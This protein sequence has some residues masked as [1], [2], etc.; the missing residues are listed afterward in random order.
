[1]ASAQASLCETNSLEKHLIC[2]ICMDPF[3]DPVTTACG[4]SFCKTCLDC[5]FTYNDMKCPL[6]KELLRKT[7]DVN[8]ILRNIVEHMNK[9]REKDA[10]EYTGAPAEVA[11]DICTERKLKAKKSCLVCLA[12]YCSTHL[13]NHS[14]TER[15]KGH[16]LVEP[17]ENLDERACLKHGRPLELY[18]RKTE[19]CICALCIEE[20]QEEIV[21]TEDEWGKKKAKL[22][23][24]KTELKEK[25]TKRKTRM[26]EIDTSL[27]SCKDQLDTEWWDIDTVFTAVTAIVEEARATALKPLE[28]RREDV[29]KE[30]KSIK[31]EL[32]A[33]INS[34]EKTISELDNIS[35]LQDHILFLQEYPSLQKLDNL[36]DSTGVELHTSLS[37][38]TLRK[39]TTTM[40]EQ[41]QQRLEQLTSTELQRL[42]KFRVDVKLDPTTAHRRLVLSDDGKEVRDKGED[43][44]VDD[45][46]E[47]FDLFASILGLDALSSGKSFWEVE[48]GN[49]TGWDLG[50]ARSDANRKGK[51]P[52]NP[53]GG[54]WVIVH[55]EEEKYAAMT[56]PPVGLY[57]KEK[58]EKVGVFV[59]TK[60][61]LVSFYD[62]TAKSHIYSFTEGSFSDDLLPY[63]S[64]HEKKD[65]KNADP[66]IISAYKHCKQD[67]DI[68]AQ[69]KIFMSMSPRWDE[70]RSRRET[71][72]RQT[73]LSEPEE[74][75]GQRA[76]DKLNTSD[77]SL[78][79]C[80]CG[81]SKVTT[82]HGLRTHQGKMGCTPRGMSIPESEQFRFSSYR[83]ELTYQRPSIKVE[84]PY[85]FTP[86]LKSGSQQNT[87]VNQKDSGPLNWTTPV[88]TE[89]VL[90]SPH[91]T[92]T[93]PATDDALVE[94]VKSMMGKQILDRTN[95]ALHFAGGAQSSLRPV[96]QI[97]S[98]Q[99]NPAAAEVTGKETDQSAFQTP[100]HDSATHQ[101]TGNARRAL[102]FSTSAQQVGQQVWDIP[103]TTAQETVRPKEREQEKEKEKEDQKLQKARQ[104]RMRA[105]LQQNIQ[106][107]EQKMAEVRSSVKACKGGL[108]AEWLQINN[109]FSEVMRVV[110]DTRQKALQ[111]L[112]ERRKRAKREAQ[113]LVQ[114]LQ[115]EIDKLKMT[116]D[117][118]DK[119]P[120]LVSPQTGLGKTCDWRNVTVDT[121]FS[122]GTLRSTTS[123]MMEEIHQELDKLSS[124]ELKR[125]PTF[126]VDVKLDPTTAHPCLVLSPNMKTVRDGGK[127]QKVPDSPQ[128]FDMFGSVLGLD[129]LSSGKSYW[130]VEVGNKTGWDLGVARRG[131]NR[132]GKLPLN[133]D[134]GYWVIVHYEEK[135]AAMAAPPAS[136]SLTGKPQ[137]VGV[138][139]D[140]EEGL[141]SFYHVTAKSH[142]YSFTECSF[143]DEVFPYFSPHLKQNE[144]NTHPLIISAVK[145]QQ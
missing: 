115:K 138:F 13:E 23:S 50:V 123:N 122:F 45:A 72:D 79:V 78:Q 118:L 128:R 8:I 90:V 140:Y 9:A 104:D 15:L 28:E 5:T 93:F 44:E 82:Y 39:T 26:D 3:V 31:E 114:K 125:I 66:L 108:D 127:S 99:V 107:R 100:P 52:L 87:W 35:A 16:K 88:R 81:W 21:S 95:Q 12:S 86:P 144:R 143:S 105:D 135:Y 14:S 19:R 80:Y 94:M 18:S 59:D 89:N 75:R 65:E 120:D 43:Q 129:A 132:K 25:I 10:D 4:H 98:T 51:L 73:D 101:T 112:E 110:E 27:K 11:C 36:K 109:V 97:F 77:M 76:R 102:D 83:P 130:E 42:P 54:Y 46:P 2:S 34:L 41:I 96:S 133:P 69:Y 137:K 47:R 74:R 111:P 64:P 92:T 141:V 60:K 91:L 6:C 53:D 30:A 142:I 56:A 63:F 103:T 67:M 32:E 33:E 40:L 38:G 49:K 1:M 70:Q 121:S 48:V 29:Q 55:Y 20:G 22:E 106:T 37:F 134:G 7:P 57:L 117:E 116:I 145:Q 17:V 61:G 139:V 124:V 113:D 24:T 58:P 71:D 136:L 131:A 84:E 126:A 85:I 119:H 68:P 62:M